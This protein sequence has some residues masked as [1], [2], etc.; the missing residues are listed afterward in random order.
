MSGLY[1][2]GVE[3]NPFGSKFSETSGGQDAGNGRRTYTKPSF[4]L[5]V[6]GIPDAE[7]SD[8]VARVF[9]ADRGFLQCRPVG[10][11][12]TRR[13]VFVD[14][15]SIENATAA[16]QA[17]QGHKWEDVDAGL[18]I[19][20]DQDARS[21]RNTALD[22]GLYEK[23]WAIGPRI[24]RPP[25]DADLF[26]Q[27]RSE[28]MEAAA[29]RPSLVP[30]LAPQSSMPQKA[31]VKPSVGAQLKVKTAGGSDIVGATGGDMTSGQP[32]SGSTPQEAPTPATGNTN[33]EATSGTL[34]CLA[35]YGSDM[36]ADEESSEEE[37]DESSEDDNDPV[38]PKRRRVAP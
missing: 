31:K 38:D 17:H 10:H 5:F 28:A 3:A 34:G 11:K 32:R 1:K 35:G 25:S 6:V 30:A 26:T 19:D 27:L 4:T 21:K 23:F 15:D 22:Q 13:M 14:Y 2:Q 8:A 18:K 16:M 36:S 9:D 37:D 33:A 7:S 29:T 20:Y 24:A 12:Q